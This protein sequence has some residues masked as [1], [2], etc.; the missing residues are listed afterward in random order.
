ME[1]KSQL[2]AR[3]AE[4]QGGVEAPRNNHDTQLRERIV[5]EFR[6]DPEVVALTTQIKTTTEQLEHILKISRRE[7]DPARVASR[8]RLASLEAEYIALWNVRSEQIRKKL[9]IETGAPGAVDN[10]IVLKRKVDQLERTRNN[11]AQ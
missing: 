9:L 4:S 11:L 5:E 1:V 8:Q 10:T 7:N 6:G 2:Q 3:L